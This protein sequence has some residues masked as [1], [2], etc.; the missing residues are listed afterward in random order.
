M[1]DAPRYKLRVQ[2]SPFQTG[3][4]HLVLRD[5]QAL[6][7]CDLPRPT[8]GPD[9]A[10]DA[11]DLRLQAL[12]IT[13]HSNL[14]QCYLGLERFE[15][16]LYAANLALSFNSANDKCLYRKAKALHSLSRD[17][18][19]SETID[20]LLRLQ[21]ENKAA[22]ALRSQIH[23][24]PV[25]VKTGL[26]SSGPEAPEIDKLHDESEGIKDVSVQAASVSPSPENSL[27][28]QQQPY[29]R[30]PAAHGALAAGARRAFG[31]L[32]EDKPEVAPGA[33]A[34]ATAASSYIDTFLHMC[35]SAVRAAPFTWCG[36]RR[37]V[38][39]LR[40]LLGRAGQAV[41][42]GGTVQARL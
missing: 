19:A 1:Y 39:G 34:T 25:L 13:L 15:D 28:E 11:Y 8:E 22:Q 2:V 21:P 35:D 40:R 30:R 9:A 23:S 3:P 18:E 41:T 33:L 17:I 32:Y 29:R 14:A 4:L 38:S 6:Q 7:F 5:L 12:R 42:D 10:G 16:A 31:S 24:A 26:D 27:L 37:V 20:T 36:C